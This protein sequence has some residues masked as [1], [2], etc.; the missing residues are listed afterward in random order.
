MYI[1]LNVCV[2]LYGEGL[3]FPVT[4]MP[5]KWGFFYSEVETSEGIFHRGHKVA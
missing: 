4:R 2:L 3:P 5:G 1:I